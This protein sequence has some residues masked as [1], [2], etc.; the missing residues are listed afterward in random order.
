M[1]RAHA[2]APWLADAEYSGLRGFA[3]GLRQNAQAVRAALTLF[4][5][6]GQVE[7]Q[8]TRLKL[9]EQ[10]GYGRAKLDPLRASLV[11]AARQRPAPK[12]RMSRFSTPVHSR[13]LRV[14]CGV[15][16]PSRILEHFGTLWL[17]LG[18]S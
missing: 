7:G 13:G 12:L 18:F 6:S 4:G 15:I 3:T 11:R 10:Q 9:I 5:S 8:V 17:H 2:L 14:L 16:T 1:V